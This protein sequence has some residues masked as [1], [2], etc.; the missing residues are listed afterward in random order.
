VIFGAIAVMTLRAERCRDACQGA[1]ERNALT[2]RTSSMSH[3]ASDR[4]S[5]AAPPL[6]TENLDVLS[7]VAHALNCRRD[8]ERQFFLVA[9]H[10]S[11]HVR[12]AN[13]YFF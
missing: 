8:I 7:L 3:A 6:C 9:P 2:T 4:G 1:A 11:A 13:A 5:I 10:V 12:S